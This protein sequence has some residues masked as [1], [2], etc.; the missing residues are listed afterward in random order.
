V[1]NDG[2]IDISIDGG[3]EPY[4]ISWTGTAGA[5]TGYTS[6]DEDIEGLATGTYAVV[7]TDANG[8]TAEG[9]AVIDVNGLDEAL[10]FG[11]V[12]FPNPSTD[13]ATL[14]WGGSQA[15][16]WMTVTDGL[17]RVVES[18]RIAGTEGRMELNAGN[19]SA[20]VYTI[21]VGASTGVSTQRW[22]IAN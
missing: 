5:A 3:V 13:A 8:C 19:F 17:G 15:V 16:E 11:F 6:A 22:V 9:E 1:D 4:V 20:G 21:S 14:V 2:A 10:G 12:V 18:V 7:V